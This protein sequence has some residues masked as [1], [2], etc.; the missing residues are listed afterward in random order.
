[1]NSFLSYG[2]RYKYFLEAMNL[3]DTDT[4][5]TK[6]ADTLSDTDTYNFAEIIFFK[7]SDYHTMHIYY[8]IDYCTQLNSEV[9]I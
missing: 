9:R 8:S 3:A 5:D 1:M 2:E 6:M 4:N 7:Y